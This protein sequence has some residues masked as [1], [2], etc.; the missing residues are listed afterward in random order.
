MLLSE[1]ITYLAEDISIFLIFTYFLTIIPV[2]WSNQSELLLLA[3]TLV[4]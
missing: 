1:G 2:I 3:K 4:Y